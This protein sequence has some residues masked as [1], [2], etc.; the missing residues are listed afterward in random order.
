MP[1]LLA[2]ESQTLPA[3]KNREKPQGWKGWKGWKWGATQ[4]KSFLIWKWPFSTLQLVIWNLRPWNFNMDTQNDAISEKRYMLKP[5]NHQ[6][7]GIPQNIRLIVTCE[8]GYQAGTRSAGP[9]NHRPSGRSPC[10]NHLLHSK[11]INPTGLGET[12]I[13]RDPSNHLLQRFLSYLQ[14][15]YWNKPLPGYSNPFHDAQH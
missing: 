5:S 7:V 9:S 12:E 2:L 3:A 13:F 14:Q 6:C 15:S 8:T 11:Q 10:N 4:K 1:R